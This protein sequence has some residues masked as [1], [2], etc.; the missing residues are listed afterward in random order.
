MAIYR[1]RNPVEISAFAA[2]ALMI[3]V[4]VSA[5]L[6]A[7]A[8]VAIPSSQISARVKLARQNPRQFVQEAVKSEVQ[9]EQ[10]DTTHWRFRK[11]V[12][13]HGVSK[14]WDV[15]ETKKG[16]VQRLIAID[17]HPLN[18]Q[19]QQAEE[20][21]MQKF[22][23]SAAQQTKKRG[24]SSSDYNREQRL[25]RMLPNALL[26]TYAGRDGDLVTLRFR[27]NPKFQATSHEAQVFHHM[28]GKLVVNVSNMRVAQFAGRIATPVEFLW[29]LL[30]HLNAGGTFNVK[31][32]YVAPDHWDLAF[33]DTNITGK[34]LFFKTI[35]VQEK[36]VESDYQ[37]VSDDLTLQQAADILKNGGGRSALTAGHSPL[38]KGHTA[39]ASAS[40]HN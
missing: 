20:A 36:E 38:R 15:I 23:A 19:Q 33:L 26:Y 22:L 30:G 29:G 2:S 12:V 3:L 18:A 4:F 14:T 25:M 5:L 27:P 1:S 7:P 8:A 37:R 11:L 40:R 32:G 21:R 35:S 39:I 16:E 28:V 31:Q 13:E 24:A 9:G 6:I 34:A 17:G 10:D